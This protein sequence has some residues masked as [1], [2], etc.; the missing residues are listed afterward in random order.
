MYIQS[1][2]RY[3]LPECIA[4]RTTQ[5][6]TRGNLVAES[7]HCSLPRLRVSLCQIFYSRVRGL[8]KFKTLRSLS[9]EYD[10]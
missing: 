7:I 10:G 9:D 4:S 3:F 1:A 8:T 5:I 2:L 6:K